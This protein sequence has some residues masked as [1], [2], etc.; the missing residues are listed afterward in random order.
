MPGRKYPPVGHVMVVFV[1]AQGSSELQKLHER[2]SIA[3][4]AHLAHTISKRQPEIIYCPSSLPPPKENSVR[5]T[6]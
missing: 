2:L 6:T 5:L 1:L 3:V 4:Q